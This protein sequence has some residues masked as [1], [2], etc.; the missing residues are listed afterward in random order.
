MRIIMKNVLLLFMML[1]CVSWLAGGCA[2]ISSVSAEPV[3]NEGQEYHFRLNHGGSEATLVHQT[4]EVFA[5]QVYEL[6]NGQIT[7]EIYPNAQ[8][9][10]ES[11]TIEAVQTGDIEMTIVNSGALVPFVREWGV[12]SAPFVFPD[13]ET[14]YKVLDGSFGDEMVDYLNNQ[15]F[16]G[17]GFCESVAF[18]QTTSSKP[19]RTADDLK[20]LRIRVMDN[21]VQLR[22]WQALGAA[23]TPIPFS[24]LYT[25]LQQGTVDAMENPLELITAMRFYEVQDSITLTNHVF[26]TSQLIISKRVYN[27]LP[28]DLQDVVQEAGKRAVQWQRERYAELD[29]KMLDILKEN[30]TEVIELPESEIEIL[31]ERSKPAMDFIRD[32]FG[33]DMVDRLL[34][35]VE[36]AQDK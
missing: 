6:S 7:I 2:N 3:K 4:M 23:P 28:I 11:T 8:L 10:P 34:K 27:N 32:Q 36:D 26:Q 5:E 18:R 21:P 22:I 9:G 25:A 33:S 19:I 30:G 20:G 24:E 16:V 1:V 14:A 29:Q 13:T 15:G 35:A 17:L 12:L 31:R